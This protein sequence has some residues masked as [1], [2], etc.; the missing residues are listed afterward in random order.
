MVFVP[1]PGTEV[2]FSIWETRVRDYTGYASA[3]P[4]ASQ[5]W[6][7]VRFAQTGN[8]PVVNVSLDDAIAFCGWLTETERKAGRLETGKKYRLPTDAEWSCAVGI[9]GREHGAT[10]KE[11]A[12]SLKN[13]YPWGSEWPPPIG[14]GN[15]DPFWGTDE[16]DWTSPVGSFA[17]NVF[18]LYDMGGNVWE[19]CLDWDY[20][21]RKQIMLRGASWT[22]TAEYSLLSSSRPYVDRSGGSEVGGFRVVLAGTSTP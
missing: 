14:V 17:P 3:N 7:H 19:W 15:Y 11:K 13:V 21:E 10:A 18:G 6:K 9:G 2:L 16:Y 22:S 4:A 8:H 12:G 5:E 20:G 1:V